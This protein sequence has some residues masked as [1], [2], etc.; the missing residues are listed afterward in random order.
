MRAFVLCSRGTEIKR[1]R[2]RQRQKDRERTREREIETDRQRAGRKREINISPKSY[3]ELVREKGSISER[4]CLYE[5]LF[6]N[7]VLWIMS[8]SLS[9]SLSVYFLNLYMCV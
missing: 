9:L 4:L 1:D 3:F 8:L 7:F 5:C 2:R 6:F